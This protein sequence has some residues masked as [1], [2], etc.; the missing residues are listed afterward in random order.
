MADASTR[1]N[2]ETVRA[3]YDAYESRDV[4][5]LMAPLHEDFEVY[6]SEH[7]PWGGT[8]KG[9]D[10]MMEFIQAITSHID[11]VVVVEELVESGDDVIMLGRSRGKIKSTGKEYEVRLVDVIRLREGKILKLDIY[12]DMAAILPLLGE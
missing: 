11:S 10:G 8:Y 2:L 9:R 1:Q 6:Q 5:G 12:L 3:L 7:L 4:E